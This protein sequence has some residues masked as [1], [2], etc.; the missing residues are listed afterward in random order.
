M[1]FKY[2]GKEPA[3]GLDL[4]LNLNTF[5]VTKWR[6]EP[7]RCCGNDDLT[8][9]LFRGAMLKNVEEARTT[10]CGLLSWLCHL[11]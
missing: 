5:S 10:Q 1:A 6:N 9:T 2:Q 8:E 4:F 11:E 3:L 7:I